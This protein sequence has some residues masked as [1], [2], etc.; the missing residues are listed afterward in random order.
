MCGP[1]QERKE[2]T[3]AGVVQNA[4]YGCDTFACVAE[5]VGGYYIL[6]A[7]LDDVCRSCVDGRQMAWSRERRRRG[8]GNGHSIDFRCVMQ[9]SKTRLRLMATSDES[10]EE[11]STKFSQLLL[12]L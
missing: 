8:R 9:N 1:T 10:C 7:C 2:D 5:T 3:F 12:V 6:V 11:R 4:G